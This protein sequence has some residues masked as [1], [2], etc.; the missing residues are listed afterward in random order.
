MNIKILHVDGSSVVLTVADVKGIGRGDKLALTIEGHVEDAGFE[1]DEINVYVTESYSMI[2]LISQ[3]NEKL[4]D[5]G[6]YR[7]VMGELEDYFRI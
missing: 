2:C 3:V 6:F 4:I 7:A 5:A 1:I